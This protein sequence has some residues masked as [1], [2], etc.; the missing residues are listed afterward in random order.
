MSSEIMNSLYIALIYLAMFGI[1]E[2]LYHFMHVKAEMTRKFSHLSAGFIAFLFPMLIT[3]HI[4]VLM[5]AAGFTGLLFLTKKVNLLKSIHAV[6]RKTVGS[7]LYPISIYGCF[8]VYSHYDNLLFYYLPLLIL[9]ISDTIAAIGG[10]AWAFGRFFK[11]TDSKTLFG[12]SLFFV[13]AMVISIVVLALLTNLSFRTIIILSILIS[14]LTSFIEA[15]SNKGL[16]NI[17]IP[18]TVLSILVL[19][20]DI[21]AN[22]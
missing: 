4:F 2:V 20:K 15:I 8:L 16:D 21:L 5:L 12:S 18:L 7:Y 14:L 3:H 6:K 9:A 13:S 19:F 1:G 22:L 10:E 11:H 17:T